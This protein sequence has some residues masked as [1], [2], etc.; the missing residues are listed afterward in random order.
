MIIRSFTPLLKSIG[1][2][3]GWFLGSVWLTILLAISPAAVESICTTPLLTDFQFV[4][5][6]KP[7]YR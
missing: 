6:G 3:V 1:W 7:F 4:I 5:A 2:F